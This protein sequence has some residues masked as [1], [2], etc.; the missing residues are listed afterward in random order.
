[1]LSHILKILSPDMLIM[2]VIVCVIL[3]LF[4]SKW[5]AICFLF[6]FPALL[7][8]GQLKDFFPASVSAS[9]AL[10]PLVA[11][12]GQVFR[13]NRFVFKRCE[14]LLIGLALLMVYS[15]SYSTYPTY[16][17][18]KAILFCFMVVPVIIFAPQVIINVRALR[19]VVSI[20]TITFIIYVIWSAVLA[21]GQS[22]FAGRMS[23]L[24]D[25]ICAGQFLGSASIVFFVH[26]I[27]GRRRA[28]NKLFYG[29]LMSVSLF[30]LFIT[31]TRAALL[32]YILTILFIYWFVYIDWYQRIFNK[33]GVTYIIILLAIIFIAT[34]LFFVKKTISIQS[35]NRLNSIQS[36][37]SNFTSDEIKNWQYS[38]GRMVNYFSAIE[39]F[40]SHPLGGVGAGGYG[41]V[42]SGYRKIRMY[43]FN[44]GI[45]H[46]YPHN[47]ILEFAVEQGVFGLLIILYILFLNFRMILHLRVYIHGEPSHRWIV[48]F[49]VS[50][51][52][53][54]LLVSMTSL[55]IP[56][57]MILWWG[58]GLL[59]AVDRVYNQS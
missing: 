41:S 53:Y 20:I 29:C 21:Q 26:V 37:F 19:K 58:M 3:I 18:D 30:L 59:L 13:S 55:D 32:A 34:G 49:C 38:N 5:P 33:A 6:G 27:F 51:Y 31:G 10:F 25:V 39:G 1:M 23:F 7:F 47:M 36:F 17:R 4:A 48:T 44:D 14:K 12:I 28:G 16:G 42:L 9:A 11:V 45:V 46:S 50:I 54:G 15:I 2:G 43:H 52:V 40:I 8:M 24:G 35:F 57:M 56:R 22:S